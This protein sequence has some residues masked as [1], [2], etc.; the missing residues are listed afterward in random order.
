[1]NGMFIIEAL[2]SLSTELSDMAGTI[3]KCS[4]YD[5]SKPFTGDDACRMME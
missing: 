4:N 1:M 3:R 5:I 2:F